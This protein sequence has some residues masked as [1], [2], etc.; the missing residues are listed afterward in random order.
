MLERIIQSNHLSA[1]TT[2]FI[3]LM[4]VLANLKRDFIQNTV[5]FF[6]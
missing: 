4:I 6:P 5:G 2:C 1:I 3:E